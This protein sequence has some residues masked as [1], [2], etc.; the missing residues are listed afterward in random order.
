MTPYTNYKGYKAYDQA[1]NTFD[2][3]DDMYCK[4]A[5]TV[6]AHYD[7]IVEVSFI[8]PWYWRLSEIISLFAGVG[9]LIYFIRV[10]NKTW[11]N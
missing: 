10:R 3:T 11:K 8:E 6:P 2:I 4:V 7:G 1:G 5:F 9:T